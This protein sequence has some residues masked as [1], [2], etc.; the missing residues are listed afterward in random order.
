MEK[1]TF[2]RVSGGRLYRP[3]PTSDRRGSTPHR[4]PV[5]VVSITSPSEGD[6]LHIDPLYVLYLK[7]VRP[8]HLFKRYCIKFLLFFS[9]LVELKFNNIEKKHRYILVDL[10]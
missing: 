6:Q 10:L 3:A 7:Q 8:V 1:R 5:C 4:P 2:T 9:T